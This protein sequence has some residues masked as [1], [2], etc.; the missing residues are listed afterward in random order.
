M[1]SMAGRPSQLGARVLK[2]V[3]IL[4]GPLAAVVGLLMLVPAV[5]DATAKGLLMVALI[6]LFCSIL[7]TPAI[8]F[9]DPGSPP[10]RSDAGDGDGGGGGGGDPPDP[11]PRPSAPRGGI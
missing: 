5:D 11:S 9:P 10:P 8:L 4:F 3:L 2:L 1:G 7:L 6:W